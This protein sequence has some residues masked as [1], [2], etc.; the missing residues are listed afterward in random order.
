[1]SLM[2]EAL[3]AATSSGPSSVIASQTFSN[4]TAEINSLL[5]QLSELEKQKTRADCNNRRG[6]YK[7]TR[8]TRE[9]MY[10][11]IFGLIMPNNQAQIK[12]FFSTLFY[13]NS[14]VRWPCDQGQGAR[15][16]IFLAF[17]LILQDILQDIQLAQ[18][19]VQ[20]IF[21]KNSHFT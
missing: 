3:I 8:V 1:M 12:Q 21:T 19:V 10:A 15:S 6:K 9:L 18:D 14:S 16:C 11:V 20:D 4:K 7:D 5:A 17:F 13:F 2:R